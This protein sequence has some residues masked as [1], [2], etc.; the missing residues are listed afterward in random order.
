MYEKH[1]KPVICLLL[2]LWIC[3]IT[4]S[5]VWA[6]ESS[7]SQTS[8]SSSS[9]SE[10][11]A[12]N[13]ALAGILSDAYIVMEADSGQ[14]LVEKNMDKREYPASI[15]KILTVALA[16]ENM[17]LTD[18][19]VM[20]EE[21]VFSIPRD[22]SHIALTYGE[23]VTIEQLVYATMLMSAND[24]AN[25]LA[26]AT[27]GSL[28]AF[29]E[30][31]N[32]KLQEIGAYN[33]HFT[34]AH[35][36]PDDNH[37]TTA[38]DMAIITQY[39]MSVPGFLEVFGADSYTMAPT[40]KQPEERPFGTAHSM[41]VT[42]AFTY[43]GAFGGK[44]GWTEEANHTSV[45]TAKRGDMTLICVSLKT[46]SRYDKYEDTATLFDYCFDNFQTLT[47]TGSDLES[48]DK[49]LVDGEGNTVGTVHIEAD[50]SAQFPLR[51]Y[52]EYL[53]SDV[54]IS[55]KIQE[56]Y[57]QGEEISPQV[58]LTIAA[59][60]TMYGQLGAYP[61]T[62]TATEADLPVSASPSPG[63]TN[64]V[65]KVTGIVAKTVLV[66]L[67]IGVVACLGIRQV[68]LN[69]QRKRLVARRRAY[70]RYNGNRFR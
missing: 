2:A 46:A 13:P 64:T 12:V 18:T 10:A 45:T 25:G 49:P 30:M 9:S 26:E 7:Q 59:G 51:L 11:A 23:E 52:K 33:T 8:Q 39:A 6:D 34:N 69:R 24:A 14:I 42:S 20:S 43:E 63:N 17:D 38:R 62:Y 67:G 47:L 36:L 54:D 1:L 32:S 27:A 55:Y 57:E 37:Y 40:N 44:L 21:A 65:L 56:Q 50:A 53:L 19:H 4:A 31:M 58:I 41:L 60:N 22:S 28:E 5:T 3:L 48:F 35:G 61:L 15:T 66:V 68:N 29:V 16:L 70:R